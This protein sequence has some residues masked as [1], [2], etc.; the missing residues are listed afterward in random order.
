MTAAAVVHP[1]L[2]ASAAASPEIR[3][4]VFISGAADLV[5]SLPKATASTVGHRVTLITSSLSVTT[6]FSLSPK[7]TDTINGT[8]ITAA[9]DK[10]IINTGATDAVGDQLCVICTAPAVW[11]IEGKIGTWARE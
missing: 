2:T 7:S 11:W 8:G 6:G 1:V 5:V 9:A 10:D 3:D 4:Q